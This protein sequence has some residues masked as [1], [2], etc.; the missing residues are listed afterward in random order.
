[1][2]LVD[3]KKV[4]IDIVN[5]ILSKETRYDIRGYDASKDAVY[6]SSYLVLKNNMWEPV[7]I[8]YIPLYHNESAYMEV[9]HKYVIEDPFD[10]FYYYCFQ[11]LAQLGY[12]E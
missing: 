9:L 4:P 3:R 2:N 6:T 8:I 7:G 1:M 11:Y 10:G 12:F 5:K